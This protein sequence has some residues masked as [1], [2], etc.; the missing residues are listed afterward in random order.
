MNRNDADKLLAE[1]V[2]A[3][4]E[5]QDCYEIWRNAKLVYEN[6]HNSKFDS[7][8]VARLYRDYTNKLTVQGF[9]YEDIIQAMTGGSDESR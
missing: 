7:K 9:V 1:Y 4:S 6:I 5:T 3:V 8:D 2:V